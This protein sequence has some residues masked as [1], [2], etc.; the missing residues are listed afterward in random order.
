MHRFGCGQSKIIHACMKWTF[1]YSL[2]VFSRRMYRRP[3]D[4]GDAVGAVISPGTV[5][6]VIGLDPKMAWLKLDLEG[7]TAWLKREV[8]SLF[9]VFLNCKFLS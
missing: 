1:V 5:L 7:A 6:H 4:D 8:A 3:S 9:L 2:F